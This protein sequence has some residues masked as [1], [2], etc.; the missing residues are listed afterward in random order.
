MGVG[1]FRSLVRTARGC[2][3]LTATYYGNTAT[4][5][6]NAYT[7]SLRF[8]SLYALLLIYPLEICLQSRG[9]SRS[10]GCLM[11]YEV[12]R[13]NPGSVSKMGNFGLWTRDKCATFWPILAGIWCQQ[14]W[15]TTNGTSWLQLNYCYENIVLS[16][17]GGKMSRAIKS[18]YSSHHL[19]GT[20]STCFSKRKA[21]LFS[22]PVYS[23]RL[24]SAWFWWPAPLPW[25]SDPKVTII[26]APGF[27]TLLPQMPGTLLTL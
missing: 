10:W 20:L 16:I 27:Q 12:E 26:K 4:G 24:A 21:C 2:Q 5:I 3:L 8:L 1:P 13:R 9:I 22:P 25:N 15:K 17:V 23:M 18:S 14:C 19:T 6:G 7:F 11:G